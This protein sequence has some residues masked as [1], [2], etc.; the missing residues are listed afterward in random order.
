MSIKPIAV[1]KLKKGIS[2]RELLTSQ[3]TIFVIYP[4]SSTFRFFVLNVK[5]TTND[6]EAG[7]SV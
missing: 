6:L 4:N 3:T 5:M 7:E 2:S 1:Q